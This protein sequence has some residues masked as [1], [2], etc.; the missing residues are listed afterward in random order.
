[1]TIIDEGLTENHSILGIHM[2][3]NKGKIDTLGK[4]MYVYKVRIY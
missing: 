1:M 3:G 4:S 2:V